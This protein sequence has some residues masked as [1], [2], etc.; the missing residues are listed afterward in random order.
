[1]AA[2]LPVVAY[3]VGG[4]SE[5]LGHQRGA[6]IPAGDETSFADAVENLL[7]D[8]ALRQKLGRAPYCSH[9]KLQPQLRAPAL[10]GTL[11]LAS[12]EQ[13]PKEFRCMNEPE[14]S[15]AKR[16]RVA[17]VAP[18]L[19]YVGGQSVQ[20]RLAPAAL[21]NDPDIDISSSP[22]I[23]P[24]PQASPGRKVFPACAQFCA[25]PSTS[26]TSGAASKT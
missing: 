6:L 11:C 22:S 24:L 21:A 25:S 3:G 23:H 26:G 4:N 2:G 1:M 16:P 5:L 20:A 15:P 17:I 19:R 7:A 12:S 9:K 8:S 18:S 13:A 14:P 10:R